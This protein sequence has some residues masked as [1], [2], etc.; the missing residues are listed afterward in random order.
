M[1]DP[2]GVEGTVKEVVA[3]SRTNHKMPAGPPLDYSFKDLVSVRG[4]QVQGH[5]SGRIV[6]GQCYGWCE[7]TYAMT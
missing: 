4:M 3:S 2:G 7:G 5:A 6:I 1:M